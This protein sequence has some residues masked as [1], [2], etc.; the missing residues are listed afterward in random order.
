MKAL[1]A[2]APRVPLD[3]AAAAST[4]GPGA[5]VALIAGLQAGL[6]LLNVALLAPVACVIYASVF[7][8]RH[9]ARRRT[10]QAAATAPPDMIIEREPQVPV[11]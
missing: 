11:E 4:L 7:V 3:D 5:L 2:I 9:T 1:I 10:L 6:G 8:Y